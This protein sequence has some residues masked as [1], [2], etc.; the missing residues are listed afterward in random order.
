[1]PLTGR[2]HC[3]TNEITSIYPLVVTAIEPTGVV[4][5]LGDVELRRRVG[6]QP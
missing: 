5:R 3:V 6:E 1:M 4:F 2:Q